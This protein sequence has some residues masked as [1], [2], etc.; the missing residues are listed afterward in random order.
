M[1]LNCLDLFRI[2]KRKLYEKKRKLLKTY[3]A[4]AAL[5]GMNRSFF[6]GKSNCPG[7]SKIIW[8]ETL[9]HFQSFSDILDILGLSWC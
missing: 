2:L 8:F 6:C 7:K 3:L 4:S 5:P 9:K 1:N